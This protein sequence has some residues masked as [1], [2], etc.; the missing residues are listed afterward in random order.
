[1]TDFD[2]DEYFDHAYMVNYEL[3]KE[4]SLLA[5]KKANPDMILMDT[6]TLNNLDNLTGEV[7]LNEN[8]DFK[9]TAIDDNNEEFEF[10]LT[11]TD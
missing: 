7:R 10:I 5:K 9:I 8:R 6:T 1:M 4:T 11:T 2:K 3:D